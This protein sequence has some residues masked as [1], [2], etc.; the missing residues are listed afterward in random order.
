MSKRWPMFR[1]NEHK[2]VYERLPAYLDRQLSDRECVR[3]ES[4]LA[5]CAECR[6]ELESLRWTQNLLRQ[7]PT[8]PV[9]RPFYVREADVAPQRPAR[10]RGTLFSMQ[11]AT[12]IVALLFVVVLAGDL[13]SSRWMLGQA[14]S[15][16]IAFQKAVPEAAVEK[17]ME[18]VPQDDQEVPRVEAV[19]AETPQPEA[20]VM[21]SEPEG[22]RGIAAPT[23]T[24]AAEKNVTVPTPSPSPGEMDVAPSPVVSDTVAVGAAP[25]ISATA[26]ISWAETAVEETV[27]ISEGVAYGGGTQEGPERGF[28]TRILWRVLEVS[29][30]VALVGLVI[31]LVVLRRQ[32]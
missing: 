17:E 12:A 7:V 22:E 20:M 15:Q 28:P 9:P 4:H 8:V 32:R 27:P 13:F 21:E 1:K 10:R 5:S 25:P 3:V 18:R 29:L 16:E 19:Q 26:E 30:G 23:S 6:Q 14:G 11:W 2:Y 24:L 31:A